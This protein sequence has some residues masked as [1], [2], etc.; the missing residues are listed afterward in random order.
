MHCGSLPFFLPRTHSTD[1]AAPTTQP[2]RLV[3]TAFASTTR[4]SPSRSSLS[5]PCLAVSGARR[6]PSR[7]LPR[8][9]SS[10]AL[11]FPRGRRHGAM[12]AHP[13]SLSPVEER[14][15]C[16]RLDARPQ[17]RSRWKK[18]HTPHVRSEREGRSDD[19][20]CEDGYQKKKKE[21]SM[22]MAEDEDAPIERR[23]SRKRRRPTREQTRRICE[24]K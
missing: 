18:P 21:V 23:C 3:F 24:Q 10:S 16:L 22:A 2:P 7:L 9:R 17:G 5:A 1:A 6:T 13:P 11:S 14:E 12:S 20:E 4:W 19:D 15:K 8:S